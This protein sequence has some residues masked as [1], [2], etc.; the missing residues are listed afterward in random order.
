MTSELIITSEVF[1]K[2]TL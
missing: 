2:Q 1:K